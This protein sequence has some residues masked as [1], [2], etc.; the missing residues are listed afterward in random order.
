[1]GTISYDIKRL[2][3]LGFVAGTIRDLG[4]IELIDKI[5]GTDKREEI[6]IGESIASMV[7]NGL[8]FTSQPLSLTERFFNKKPLELL[9]GRN[10]I[11]SKYFNRNKLSKTLDRIYDY[12]CEKLFYQLSLVACSK[13]KI[14]LRCSSLDT[15][16]ISVTGEY[17]KDSD[18]NAIK[19]T[20]GFSK[21]HRSDLKQCV[22]ELLVSQDGWRTINDEK[23]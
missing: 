9:F 19:L 23:L 14:S 3:H 10:D 17:D 7:I 20:H 16:S 2:D 13:A 6:S 18:E 21:D 12:G 11:E 8:G 5:F 4:I 15:T 22:H 1:M